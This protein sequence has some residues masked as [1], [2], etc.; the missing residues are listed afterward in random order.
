MEDKDGSQLDGTIQLLEHTASSVEIFTSKESVSS[1]K[2]QRL[3]KLD[4]FYSWLSKWHSGANSTQFISAKLWFDLQSMILGI[5]SVLRI[6]LDHF[7]DYLM[8]LWILNQDLVENHFCQIRACNGQN[9]NPTYRLQESA[10][11][12]IRFDQTTVSN[13]SNAGKQTCE[14]SASCSLPFSNGNK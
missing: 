11:N 12:S 7:P 13:K 2:D 14:Q 1:P 5:K 6:N 10:Q 9:N 4:H 3:E 8:K